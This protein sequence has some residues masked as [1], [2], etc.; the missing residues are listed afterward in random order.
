MEPILPLHKRYL[1]WDGGVYENL[2]SEALIKPGKGL[3]D[4]IDFYIASDAGRAFGLEFKRFA[5]RLGFYRPP[6]RLLDCAMD[7]VRAVRARTIYGM[8]RPKDSVDPLGIYLQ[9]GLDRT[10]IYRLSKTSL[11]CPEVGPCNLEPDDAAFVAKFPTTL[12]RL[13]IK[14]FDLLLNHGY[15]VAD[16]TMATWVPGIFCQTKAC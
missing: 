5:F 1:L 6:M 11:S 7:Q 13:K 4:D 9:M 2:G 15:E 10:E 3:R 14:E 12:R 16:A 8:L